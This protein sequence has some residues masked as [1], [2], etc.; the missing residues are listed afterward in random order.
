MI[1][2][3]RNC[4]RKE[5]FNL[6]VRSLG[7][8]EMQMSQLNACGPRVLLRPMTILRLGKYFFC[9]KIPSNFLL[10]D[11]IFGIQVCMCFSFME[12]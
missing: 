8:V 3:L 5:Q 10:R 11:C 12:M 6:D 1:K 7:V 4:I 2:M 9:N